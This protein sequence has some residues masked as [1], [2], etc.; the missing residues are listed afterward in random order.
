MSPELASDDGV[1]E[2]NHDDR[3][4]EAEKAGLPERIQW[5]FHLVPYPASIVLDDAAIIIRRANT[6][7]PT[8]VLR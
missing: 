4:S 1:D 8:R 3:E 6:G 2:Q 5:I 7:N